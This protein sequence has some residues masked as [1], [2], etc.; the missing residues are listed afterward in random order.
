MKALDTSKN[1][2]TNFALRPEI[3]FIG[4]VIEPPATR[5]S[6]PHC[7]TLDFSVFPYTTLQECFRQH[8]RS[9]NSAAAVQLQSV[10]SK[11]FNGTSLSGTSVR[12]RTHELLRGLKY[13]HS[14][15]PYAALSTTMAVRIIEVKPHTTRVFCELHT[16][17]QLPKHDQLNPIRVLLGFNNLSAILVLVG[18]T[19]VQLSPTFVRHALLLGSKGY[20][21]H[22]R[23]HAQFQAAYSGP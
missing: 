18:D 10:T 13:R 5:T 9:R 23:A 22:G 8:A 17:A 4:A 21:W 20:L 14:S 19:Q 1:G 16:Q 6:V 12:D 15:K 2:L 3:G 7:T 11:S